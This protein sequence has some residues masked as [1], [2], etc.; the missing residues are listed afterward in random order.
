MF[1][2]SILVIFYTYKQQKPTKRKVKLKMEK[3]CEERINW[4]AENFGYDVEKALNTNMKPT[5]YGSW[6]NILEFINEREENKDYFQMIVENCA[7]DC[8]S[9]Y[10]FWNSLSFCLSSIVIEGNPYIEEEE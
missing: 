1:T 6:N 9:P 3:T 7:E 4:Y 10:D 2:F 8:E 5:F